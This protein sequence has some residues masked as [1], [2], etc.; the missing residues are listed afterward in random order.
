MASED[1]QSFVIHT[2]AGW[3]QGRSESLWLDDQARLILSPRQQLRLPQD[4]GRADAI[5]F[6]GL[7]G[8]YLFDAERGQLY[9]YC[10]DHMEAGPTLR[11]DVSSWHPAQVKRPAPNG[12]VR[13]GSLAVSRST[14]YVADTFNRRVLAFHLPTFRL[15]YILGDGTLP[16]AEA[17]PLRS[18]PVEFGLPTAIA[19]DQH[20]HLY[21]LDQEKKQIIKFD[22]YGLSVF[23]FTQHDDGPL[24]APVDMAIDSEDVIYIL[25]TAQPAILKFD[26]N[27]RALGRVAAFRDARPPVREPIALTVDQQGVIFVAERLEPGGS[28]IHRF[29]AAGRYLGMISSEGTC[30]QLTTAPDGTLY[31][32]C[33]SE[34]HIVRFGGSH[35]FEMQGIYYS[36]VFDSTLPD[37]EWHRLYIEANIPEKTSL[38]ISFQASNTLLSGLDISDWQ[39]VLLS[40][41]GMTVTQDALFV[42]A[43]GRYLQLK[44][45]LYGDEYHTPAIKRV[46]IYFQRD[47]YLRYLPAVYGEEP[48]SRHFLERFLSIFESTSLD[49]E[50]KIDAIPRYLDADVTEADFLDWL[51]GWLAIVSDHNWSETRK[52][53]FLAGAFELYAQRGT[54]LGLQRMIELFTDRP[55]RVVEHFRGRRPMILGAP[56]GLR[57]GQSAI[58]NAQPPQPLV[59]EESSRIGVFLL[60]EPTPLPDVSVE[61]FEL[62]A[63]D[64]TIMADT[65]RLHHESQERVLRRLIEDGKPAYMRYQL[66]TT[67]QA[68][69]QL[70]KH[71]LL[72]VDTVLTQGFQPMQVGS[73]T[74]I[75]Q[76]TFVGT[77]HYPRGT[78]GQ[79]SRLSIDTT[80]Q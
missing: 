14:L 39:T 64:L 32:L 24:Q 47:S 78:L 40:P 5:V 73:N 30:T 23:F 72:G 67:G 80:L 70:G 58:V 60:K 55:A 6:D 59:L 51:G 56:D 35:R 77:T 28:R 17:F 3:H 26:R 53:R 25:D 76:G 18:Q 12:A 61:Q 49:M 4:A 41:Q 68:A 1:F 46:Q 10:I 8:L 75:G 52:R 63:Y 22:S 9:R 42:D 29:D 19:I 13:R 21:V 44:V 36:R 65:W 27:G 7:G 11:L 66:K 74:I 38:K 57:V 16:Y 43:R 50:D 2:P 37:C 45:E 20:G 31:G 34:G 15:R 48:Q 69:M 33:R 79:R 71:S 54:P 62:H